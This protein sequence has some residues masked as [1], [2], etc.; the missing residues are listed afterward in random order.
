LAPTAAPTA[1]E[2]LHRLA[3]LVARWNPR[4]NLV[5]PGTLSDLATRHVGDSA[6]L[7][8]LAPEGARHWADLGAGGGFPGLVVAA[9]A[10]DSRPGLRVTLVESD[11]RKAVFLR[12]AAREMGLDVAVCDARA[13]T[14]A[15]LGADVVSAR[16][17]A[18]LPRLLPLVARHLAPGGI[19][20]LMKGQGWEAEVEAARAQGWRFAHQALPSATDPA[21]RILRL[22]APARG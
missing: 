10:A 15:P 2:R 11:A 20:L 5:A 7:L 13:E 1:A 21:A 18:P 14:L 19:A 8:P 9:L 17:L 16:A 4:I 3:A 22:Q 12:Q 6:Q